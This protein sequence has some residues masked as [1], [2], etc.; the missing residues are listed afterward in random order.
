MSLGGS[1]GLEGRTAL[2]VGG[3]A[4]IRDVATVA[5]TSAGA[6]ASSVACEAFV[7]GGAESRPADILV[8]NCFNTQAPA[9]DLVAVPAEPLELM[10]RLNASQV[11]LP[12]AAMEKFIPAMRSRGWGRIILLTSEADASAASCTAHGAQTALLQSQ[13]RQLAGAGITVNRVVVG[14]TSLGELAAWDGDLA[15]T[16]HYFAS[17][18]S[19]FVTG[20]TLRLDVT[21]AGN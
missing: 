2:V 14:T 10:A 19:S 20:Q 1:F 11:T 12:L 17:S 16:V 7:S 5:L 21:F 15:S 6:E 13:A 4:A 8:L 18:E 9:A 3:D